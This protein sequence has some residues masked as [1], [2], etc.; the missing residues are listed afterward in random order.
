LTD[1]KPLIVPFRELVDTREPG[2]P[3]QINFP[4]SKGARVFV[5]AVTSQGDDEILVLVGD[6]ADENSQFVGYR[7]NVLLSR[8]DARAL[9]Q[10]LIDQAG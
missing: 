5:G 10:F 7:S 4:D 2:G 1:R 8:D 6:M 9:G 3:Q